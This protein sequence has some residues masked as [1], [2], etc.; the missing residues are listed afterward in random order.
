MLRMKLL[1]V[2]LVA[3]TSLC[4]CFLQTDQRHNRGHWAIIK[5]DIRMIHEDLDVLLGLDA[6]T[7]LER[8][9]R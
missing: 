7:Q 8:T 3:L 5:K 6:P 1:L 4:G 2:V 9:G